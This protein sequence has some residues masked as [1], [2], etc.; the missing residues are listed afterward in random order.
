MKV[1]KRLQGDECGHSQK[2]IVQKINTLVDAMNDLSGFFGQITNKQTRSVH[3]HTEIGTGRQV[4]CV[5]CQITTAST[6]QPVERVPDETSQKE[7]ECECDCGSRPAWTKKF[8]D[9][10][11]ERGS[12][13]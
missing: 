11:Q 2:T 3:F 1:I 9:S 6:T 10:R 4:P 13:G 12:S 8:P 7:E 5:G